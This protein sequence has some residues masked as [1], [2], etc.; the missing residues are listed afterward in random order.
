M[1]AR[2]NTL[3]FHIGASMTKKDRFIRLTPGVFAD[4]SFHDENVASPE[5]DEMLGGLAFS[6]GKPQ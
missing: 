4:D 2:N 5:D 3:A 1:F 6:S